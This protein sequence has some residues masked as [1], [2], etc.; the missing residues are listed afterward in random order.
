MEDG[1]VTMDIS[2]NIH[3]MSSKNELPSQNG[4]KNEN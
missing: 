1:G 2:M 4:F 3:I